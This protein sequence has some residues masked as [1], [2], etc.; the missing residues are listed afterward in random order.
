MAINSWLIYNASRATLTNQT[1]RSGE[2]LVAETALQLDRY[3][4]QFVGVVNVSAQWHKY[5]GTN[6]D[7]RTVPFLAATLQLQPQKIVSAYYAYDLR[8]SPAPN[9]LVMVTREGRDSHAQ[10]IRGRLNL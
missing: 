6:H 7:A 4:Q 3:L 9:R 10:L 1:E 5:P 2:R 8:K